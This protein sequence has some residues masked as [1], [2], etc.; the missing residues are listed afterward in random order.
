M[1]FLF[2]LFLAG[3]AVVLVPVVLHLARRRTR[4][5]VPF[6]SLMFLSATPPRFQR[7]QRIE[8][9]ALLALRCLAL[10]LL[11]AAFARPFVPRPLPA[12]VNHPGVRT[13]LLIDTSASMRRASLWTE[14]LG[15]ARAVLGR[16]SPSD[17][18]AVM[19]FD[20]RPSTVLGFEQWAGLAPADRAAAAMARLAALE[21]SWAGTD[22]GR[23]LIGAAEAIV[24]DEG[25]GGPGA[26]RAVVVSDLQQGSRLDALSASDWPSRIELVLDKVQAAGKSNASLQALADPGA[27]VQAALRVRVNN[28]EGTSEHFRLRWEAGPAVEVAVPAGQTRVVEAPRAQTDAP[29]VLTLE[30]DDQNF[31][32][33]L[34]VA[35]SLPARVRILYVG[36]GDALDTTRPLFYLKRAFPTTRLRVP[37]IAVQEQPGA[38]EPGTQLVV[39]TGRLG[40]P[41]QAALRAHLE[42]GRAALVVL[43]GAAAPPLLPD[44]GVREAQGPDYALLTAVDLDH[45]VLAPFADS[46]YGDFTKIRFWKHRRI[47]ERRLPGARVLARFDDG[48]P[49]WLAVPVG[50]GILYLMTSG[51]QPA[52]SQL[53]LSSK[54]VP[55]LHGILEASAGLDSGQSQ[56][57]V[58]DP[59]TLPAEMGTLG[60][61]AGVVWRVR[62][63][64]G[65]LETLAPDA[66]TFAA[67]DRPGLYVLEGPSRRPFAVNLDPAE[68]AT[69]PLP[70][71]ALD[72]LGVGK[73]AAGPGSVARAADAREQSFHAAL[74]RDQALWRWLVLAVLLVVLAETWLAPRTSARTARSEA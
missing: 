68:S 3:A 37:E 16:V 63:P 54:F 59:V 73:R 56:F 31:D 49:A 19:T 50:K 15:R 64:D 20:R 47:D 43:D 38:I 14:A 25:P 7:R 34:T 36:G 69:A 53:A 11:A 22:L 29:G 52:D 55:L 48:S 62:T 72:R 46:R 70:P 9:W 2:P 66:T 26:S 60:G 39:V 6:G 21:P 8:H 13:V 1:S 12:L 44:L 5:E 71:E 41:A 33:R 23:A 27:D 32:N 4:R 58:G 65:R 74:E 30:G 51:W 28:A 24:D 40:P 18:V 45:P 61:S 42:R 17:R 35:P 67:T 57:F 10:V